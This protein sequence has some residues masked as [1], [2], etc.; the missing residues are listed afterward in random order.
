MV[1]TGR[2]TL[3]IGTRF[4][5]W[6]TLIQKGDLQCQRLLIFQAAVSVGRGHSV[7]IRRGCAMDNRF[8]ISALKVY[9]CHTFSGTISS[10]ET[11]LFKDNLGGDRLT[12]AMHGE[13]PCRPMFLL[14][15][16]QSLALCDVSRQD[17]PE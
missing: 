5:M 17:D 12:S 13:Q 9:A 4:E 2:F 14:A 3:N 10:N 6:V 16:P 7:G 1:H 11:H 15:T 8:L